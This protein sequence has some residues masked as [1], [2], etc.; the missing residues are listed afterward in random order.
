MPLK[1]T[2]GTSVTGNV[3]YNKSVLLHIFSVMDFWSL[4]MAFKLAEIVYFRR[5]VK[6]AFDWLHPYVQRGPE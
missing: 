2:T 4:K 6:G 1:R 5:D 3:V